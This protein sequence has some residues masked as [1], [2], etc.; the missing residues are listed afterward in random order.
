VTA[1]E[2][3]VYHRDGDRQG[4]IVLVDDHIGK[5]WGCSEAPLQ[6]GSIAERLRVVPGEE[7][8]ICMRI[9]AP[10]VRA[11]LLAALR[12]VNAPVVRL[13]RGYWYEVHPD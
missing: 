4:P 5:C 13:A 7:M 1:P 12:R 8:P 2:M 10:A 9:V 6:I 3:H 11:E